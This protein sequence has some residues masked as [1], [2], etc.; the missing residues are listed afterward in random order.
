[1]TTVFAQGGPRTVIDTEARRRAV[2]AAIDYAGDCSRTLLLPPDATRLYSDAGPLTDMFYQELQ[3]A[4]AVDI[5]PA[6]GTHFAMTEQ[7]LRRMFGD[8]IPLDAFLVHNWR[9]DIVRLGEVPP[10]YVHEVSDGCL[11]ESMPDFSV[12]VEVNER[13]VEG[14][15]GAVMS[16]GQVVPHEVV[17]MANGIKNVLVG[18]GGRETINRT[19]FLGAAYGMEDIMG[20][21]E[22]P[23]R[24][25]MNYA[26]RQFLADL[27]VI[28]LL[29]VMARDQ[30]GRMV[31]RGLYVGD[32]HETFLQAAALSQD[33]NLT[34]VDDA[35]DRVVAYLDPQ[36]F[37]STWLG[38]KAIY[39]T[40]MLIAD[41]GELLILAPGVHTF[42]E[43][44]EIDQLVRRYGYKGTPNTLRQ[45]KEN[46]DL[47]DNLSA[48]AHLIHGS[49]EGRFRVVLATD[50][51][52]LSRK[53]VENVGFQWRDVHEAL[54]E[55]D[56]EALT[57]GPQNGYYYIS[58]PALGL[59]AER[60]KFQHV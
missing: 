43:D 23:V 11:R 17:G 18:G 24:D 2:R 10:A 42:G 52:K 49:S 55:Y 1:M 5:M 47:R 58:N 60:A 14:G 45:V 7:D 22:T 41:G 28:F 38:N 39:R 40:R 32:D 36:E 12:P 59:W 44:P 9:E 51:D 4:P 30:S 48:A 50:P 21:A 25:V 8:R 37:K 6:L 33:V 56:I 34:L 53:E 57:D 31:M 19:H 35:P 16:I 46:D 29:T 13:L 15:Y 3:G 27:P 26:H 20:R 54:R